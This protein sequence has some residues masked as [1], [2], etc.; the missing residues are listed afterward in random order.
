M[1]E[2]QMK[3]T[4][5]VLLALVMVFAFAATAMADDTQYVPYGDIAD[6]DSDIQTAI[7]RLSVLGAL[8]GYDA[9]GT[10]FAP[11]QLITREEFA[12]IGV[13]V[14]GLEDQVALYASLASAF[15]DVEEGRWSEGYINCANANG[16]MI[17]RGNGVFDPK[18]Y[19]TMQEV[20][21]VLLRAVGYDDR[22]PG[23]WPTDYNNKAVKVGLAEYVDYIGPKYATR[24]EVASMTNEA[25]DLWIVYYVE[26]EFAQGLGMVGW[27][28]SYFVDEDGYAYKLYATNEDGW[29]Y[30][31]LL[32]ET[33]G[34]WTDDDV[35]FEDDTKAFS[36][37]TAWGF[38]DFEDWELEVYYWWDGLDT[39]PLASLYGISDS[40]DLTDL[41][42][43]MADVTINEDDEVVYIDITSYATRTDDASQDFDE[44]Y[45]WAGVLMEGDYGEYWCDADDEYYAA[46]DF[47]TF[48]KYYF[49]IVD[50]ADEEGVDLKDVNPGPDYIDVE[51][52]TEDGV[53]FYLMGEGFVA[54]EDLEENDVVYFPQDGYYGGPAYSDGVYVYLVFRPAAGTLDDYGT[55][56]INVDDVDYGAVDDYSYYSVDLGSNVDPYTADTV[57]MDF[58]ADIYM[59]P[60]YAFVNFSYF[61]D[62]L[63]LYNYAILDSYVFN[64]GTARLNENTNHT[65]IVGINVLLPGDDE[66]TTI[67]FA[68]PVRVDDVS[69]FFQDYPEEGSLVEFQL[70]PDGEFEDWYL[71]VDDIFGHNWQKYNWDADVD[72]GVIE[73]VLICNGDHGYAV[74]S[75]TSKGRLDLAIYWNDPYDA[76]E[77]STEIVADRYTF[78]D[79]AVIYLV[80]STGDADGSY[81]DD[82]FLYDFDSAQSLTYDE[83][84]EMGDF[85]ARDLCVYDAD[86]TT[87]NVLY[88]C[89][90]AE[91]EDETY[92][93]GLYSG[94]YAH[95][96][97]LDAYYVVVDG[98]IITVD[99][100]L[101]EAYFMGADIAT[102][103][104]YRLEGGALVSDADVCLISD[105]NGI[106]DY[107]DDG[108]YDEIGY[109]LATGTI[110]EYS[111]SELDLTTVHIYDPDTGWDT[112]TMTLWTDTMIAG[113]DLTLGEEV[114][115][116]D[117]DEGGAYGLVAY[118][119]DEDDLYY[120]LTSVSDFWS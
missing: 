95:S 68:D 30:W 27:E 48:V 94:E 72:D 97:S 110:V 67:D 92:G 13:R 14:A 32:W 39:Y 99:E 6:Q 23:A 85:T 1:E 28:D 18:A 33:F 86:G 120:I 69:G 89:D 80:E 81:P 54:A 56:F 63:V 31:D 87:I 73:P 10:L 90:V 15:T 103:A 19:V 98:E 40:C 117:Y 76:D 60:A 57:L 65:T 79:D 62:S 71:D 20:A 93:F 78:A 91:E 44:G 102:L 84:M 109:D 24:G 4:L 70:N 9:A 106:E 43:Q 34:C 112:T 108:W 2:L 107:Y 96:V 42:W 5:V 111:G 11:D 104:A 21:T 52:P 114:D 38:E 59:A 8:K 75:W 66:L 116:E 77:D 119:A 100:D 61:Y 25:V 41:G 64:D 51:D 113:F 55:D 49:A 47:S 37:I 74:G 83:F 35:I 22:L 58:S 45:G 46:K 7:E 12:T 53:V 115:L 3:K 16:I 36:E 26:N 50:S 101:F 88:V 82:P 118:D 17:G 105:P 29:E